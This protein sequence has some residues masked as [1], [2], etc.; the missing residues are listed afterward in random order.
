MLASMS[1][2]AFAA[3]LAS[4]QTLKNPAIEALAEA[5]SPLDGIHASSSFQIVKATPAKGRPD[6]VVREQTMK[7]AMFLGICGFFDEAIDIS[8]VETAK[9]ALEPLEEYVSDALTLTPAVEAVLQAEGTEVYAGYAS[10]NN[11]GGVVLG[12]YDTVNNQ[13]FVTGATNCGSDD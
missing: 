11:T 2:P 3:K 10:G 12:V 6:A 7:Q 13:I 1:S 9:E 8:T 4:I 5:A